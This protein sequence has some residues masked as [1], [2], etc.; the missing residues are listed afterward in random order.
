M[1]APEA[2]PPASLLRVPG[3]STLGYRER[4]RLVEICQKRGWAPDWLAAAISHESAWKPDAKN[5]TSSASG[6]C[7]WTNVSAKALGTTTA[8]IRR[9]S[10]SEQLPLVEQYF[11]RASGGRP[12][13][14]NDFL[15]YGVGAAA[16]LPD[17]KP[18]C[19]LYPAGSQG[20]Q[21]NP[22]LT[23]LDGSI[24][25]QGMRDELEGYALAHSG[26][27]RLPVAIER[28]WATSGSP[29]DKALARGARALPLVLLGSL[30]GA[31][32]VLWASRRYPRRRS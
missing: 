31:G 4:S 12:I 20:A 3:L 25:V 22:A 14:P 17:L 30:A 23:D 10:V 6:I 16:C 2:K 15:T 24:T 1:A 11:V 5:P 32:V 21:A 26:K 18:G 7:Q 28:E 19:I 13:A 27:P 9:M 29:A 8:A